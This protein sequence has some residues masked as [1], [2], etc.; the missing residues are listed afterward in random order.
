MKI[1]T[2]FRNETTAYATVR[3]T[4]EE[5]QRLRRQFHA[6][7]ELL[8]SDQV[9]IARGTFLVKQGYGWYRI[10]NYSGNNWLDR[11]QF[12]IKKI[13]EWER[14]YI[15]DRN[16]LLRQLMGYGGPAPA[17]PEQLARLVNRFQE[18]RT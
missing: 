3:M 15:E 9:H 7:E 8:D 4:K 12:A 5:Y 14:R 1:Y 17:K 10:V 6:D 11:I 13:T 18:L 16:Q 2:K